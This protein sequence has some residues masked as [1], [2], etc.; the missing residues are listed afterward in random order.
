MKFKLK[1]CFIRAFYPSHNFKQLLLVWWLT[2][3]E[4][5]KRCDSRVSI[6]TAMEYLENWDWNFKSMIPISNRLAFLMFNQMNIFM[7]ISGVWWKNT[8]ARLWQIQVWIHAL[9]SN[10]E[11][12]MATHSTILAWRILR[13]EKPGG[14]LLMGLHRVGHDWSDLAGMYACI[15]E[16]N[17]NPLQYSCLENPRD[18]GGW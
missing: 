10:K 14:L 6:N 18:R 17:G 12:E 4:K 15:G 13:M 5:R 9:A 7:S 1:L 8:S 3:K 2:F 11:K 16:G